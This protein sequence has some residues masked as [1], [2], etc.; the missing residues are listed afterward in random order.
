[1]FY[2]CKNKLF[3]ACFGNIDNACVM[4]KLYNVRLISRI[5]LL[6]NNSF[7]I[8]NNLP[9][10]CSVRHTLSVDNVISGKDII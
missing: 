9:M 3:P 7:R 6:C 4:N 8:L 2:C 5:S 1:M 10:G